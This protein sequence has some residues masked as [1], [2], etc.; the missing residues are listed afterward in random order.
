MESA[1]K[2]GPIG[3]KHIGASIFIKIDW[4]QNQ[5]TDKR[6]NKL[7]SIQKVIF[8]SVVI[9]KSIRPKCSWV[10]LL[11]RCDLRSENAHVV[12]HFNEKTDWKQFIQLKF[13]TLKIIYV[14][15]TL[16]IGLWKFLL[17]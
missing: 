8:E 9:I 7:R 6:A 17:L 11:L 16:Q 5:Q 12:V 2:I 3:S 14:S 15:T 10:R 4:T 1:R 13:E